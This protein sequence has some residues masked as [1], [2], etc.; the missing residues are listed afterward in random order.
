[1]Q[2]IPNMSA[3]RAYMSYS[4]ALQKQQISLGR[5][6]SGVTINTAAD[7]PSG[8]CDSERMK[9][10]IRGLQTASQNAQDGISMLQTAE[11]GL[12]S[13]TDMLQRVK[14]LIIQCNNGT[15][16]STDI[17]NSQKEIGQLM[18]GIDN[19]VDYTDFN[20]KNLLKSGNDVDDPDVK[21][22]LMSIGAN[23]DETVDIPMYDLSLNKLGKDSGYTL[24]D[25]RNG[26]TLDLT[27][28]G[29]CDNA[30]SVVNKALD[31]VISI[32]SGYGSIENRFNVCNENSA[33]FADQIQEEQSGLCDSDIAKE[34][35]DYSTQNVIVQA[36]IAIIAQADKLPQDA[37]TILQ[38]VKSK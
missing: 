12:N 23:P 11:G 2:L 9:I 5:V 21:T 7:D 20:G 17:Q 10:Q 38:N 1:M 3:L 24:D 37:L 30:L 31:S 16:N 4:S 25:L 18:E 6:S 34:I 15:V 22:I 13:I 33:D 8:L 26:G 35:I 32:R 19:I 27:S 14:T 28:G 36:N 29:N